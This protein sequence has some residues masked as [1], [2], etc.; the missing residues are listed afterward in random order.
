MSIL[1]CERG[2]PQPLMLGLMNIQT[3][4]ELYG[5]S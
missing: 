4:L 5:S 3:Y 1:L 2:L